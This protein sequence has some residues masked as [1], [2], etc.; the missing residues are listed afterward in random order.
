MGLDYLDLYLIHFPISLRYVPIETRYPPEW[1]YDPEGPNPKIEMDFVP[2][3][4]TWHAMED[5]VHN[6]LVKNIGVCNFTVS[7]YMLLYCF[8]VIC[9]IFIIILLYVHIFTCIGTKF[10]GFT[11][12]LYY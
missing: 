7:V 10:N 1:V 8:F 6:N 9:N 5:L 3:A 11:Q 12:L 2:I 4:E